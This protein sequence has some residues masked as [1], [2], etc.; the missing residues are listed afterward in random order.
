MELELGWR[1][2]QHVFPNFVCLLIPDVHVDLSDICC[3]GRSVIVAEKGCIS[4][5]LQVRFDTT[6][7]IHSIPMMLHASGIVRHLAAGELV[8]PSLVRVAVDRLP[9]RI[10]AAEVL[11]QLVELSR[12]YCLNYLQGRLLVRLLLGSISFGLLV[13]TIIQ[14]SLRQ[15]LHCL[16]VDRFQ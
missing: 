15:N 8:D 11:Q 6:M 10:L 12:V 3:G 5:L 9:L 13:G 1:G 2:L 16:A 4:I 14:K 7:F